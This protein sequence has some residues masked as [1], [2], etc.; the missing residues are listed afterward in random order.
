MLV[1]EGDC[2]HEDE[3]VDRFLPEFFLHLLLD[4]LDVYVEVG[5]PDEVVLLVLVDLLDL[6]EVL[7]EALHLLAELVLLD[8]QLA[9]LPVDGEVD[10]LGP[11]RQLHEVAAEE[12]PGGGTG[13][14]AEGLGV[15]GLEVEDV[16]IG[17]VLG[18]DFQ[19]FEVDHRKH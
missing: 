4:L 9:E 6:P 5:Q 18:R 17:D 15:L 14:L 2:L 7:P 12:G 19:H 8:P 3:A 13:V 16:E 11:Q 10:E 1:A